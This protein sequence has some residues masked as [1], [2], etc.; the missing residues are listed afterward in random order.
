ML[1]M[2]VDT[3]KKETRAGLARVRR[4][5][6]KRAMVAGHVLLGLI[7]ACFGP[8]KRRPNGLRYF[9]MGL[10][11]WAQKTNKNKIKMQ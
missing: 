11:L 10:K 5:K 8:K 6:R 7:W 3:Q 1:A 2:H 9:Q 4:R